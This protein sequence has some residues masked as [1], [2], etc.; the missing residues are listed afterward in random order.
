MIGRRVSSNGTT[1]YTVKKPFNNG[2]GSKFTRPFD[3]YVDKD[4]P[5]QHLKMLKEKAEKN[6]DVIDYS[7]LFA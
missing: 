7:D 2:S 6:R 1:H 3:E 4:S 5:T